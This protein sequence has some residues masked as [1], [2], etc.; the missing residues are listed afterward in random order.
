MNQDFLED[1]Q[2]GLSAERK[3]LP[4]KW[5]YDERGSQL[6]EDI[7]KTE[8]YYPTRTEAAIMEMAFPEL[9]KYAPP[10]AA[11]AE[12]GSGAGIKSQRL[13]SVLKPSVYISIDVAEDFLNTSCATLTRLFPDVEVSGVVAD[14]SGDVTLPYSFFDADERLGFFPGST[15]GN[16]DDGGAE[17]FLRKSR[18]SLGDGSQFLIGIDLVKDENVLLAAYDDSEGITR[19]FTSNILR[20]MRRELDAVLDP[21]GFEAV[22]LWNSQAARMELGL[23]ARGAQEIAIGNDAFTFNDGEM[24]LT[25]YSH[26]YTEETFGALASRTG[27]SVASTWTDA[28]KWFGVFLLKAD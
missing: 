28:N 25:E 7:T 22:A 6:F 12:F 23:V 10:G 3:S 16:F 8:D 21:E 4:P 5:L 2:A 19:K 26:K 11:I 9:A 13:I 15:L 20:R 27:W 1:V 24:V 18:S 14:F 17:A